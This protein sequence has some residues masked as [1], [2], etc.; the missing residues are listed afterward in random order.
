MQTCK[1]LK[2]YESKYKHMMNKIQYSNLLMDT[3]VMGDMF[4]YLRTSSGI[5]EQ[6]KLDDNFIK[7]RDVLSVQKMLCNISQQ[8]CANDLNIFANENNLK[9]TIYQTEDIAYGCVNVTPYRRGTV[10][11]FLQISMRGEGTARL[12]GYSTNTIHHDAVCFGT[13]PDVKEVTDAISE[14]LGNN[15]R[16]I[17]DMTRIKEKHSTAKDVDTLAKEILY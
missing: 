8:L 13:T 12:T 17:K 11:L 5:L 3:H 10:F 1:K 15:E 7:S 9:S 6:N 16:I 14:Y 2:I 4:C